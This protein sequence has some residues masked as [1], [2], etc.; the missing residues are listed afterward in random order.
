MTTPLPGE[1]DV[2]RDISARL[3]EAGI[4]YMLTGSLAMSYYTTP[5]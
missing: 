2:L 3:E 4:P 5:A 1:L